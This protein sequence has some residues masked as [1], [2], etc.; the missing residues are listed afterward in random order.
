M[1]LA[2]PRD[3]HGTFEPQ[4]VEK[5]CRRL[6][7]F[8]REVNSMFS[9]GMSTRGIRKAVRDLYGVEISADLVSQVTDS[10]PE[11]WREWQSR[12]PE[13]F[14]PTGCLDAIHARSG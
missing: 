8:D 14:Y 3:R 4:L 6:P 7:D 13:C 9:K 1:E 10:V 11:E 12:P 2:A 5:Y